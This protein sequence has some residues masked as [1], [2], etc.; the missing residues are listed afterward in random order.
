MAKAGMICSLNFLFDRITSCPLT[1]KANFKVTHTI[2][3]FSFC[4]VL[5]IF[6]QHVD[7]SLN[8]QIVFCPAFSFLA[9]LSFLFRVT[10]AIS[11][12]SSVNTEYSFILFAP[13]FFLYCD[14]GGNQVFFCPSLSLWAS[15][16]E[17]CHC[18]ESKCF[19]VSFPVK[20]DDKYCI[21]SLCMIILE[22][23]LEMKLQEMSLLLWFSSKWIWLVKINDSKHSFFIR[24]SEVLSRFKLTVYRLLT[25]VPTTIPKKLEFHLRWEVL[26]LILILCER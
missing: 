8:G 14:C 18:S 12:F 26:Q 2:L 20:T 21:S 1:E 22:S 13:F 7:F 11:L 25:A 19:Y 23:V 24:L 5:E 17:S 10:A 6:S 3:L 16:Y 4:T 15:F 9:V